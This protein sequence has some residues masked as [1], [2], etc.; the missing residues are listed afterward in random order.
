MRVD[1]YYK[2][3]AHD[4]KGAAYASDTHTRSQQVGRY[5]VPFGTV[6]RGIS[7]GLA[8]EVLRV[9]RSE[10]VVARKGDPFFNHAARQ[11]R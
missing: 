7:L 11:G 5:V 8:S 4:M 10:E 3:P 9:V 6:L 1:R 2:G